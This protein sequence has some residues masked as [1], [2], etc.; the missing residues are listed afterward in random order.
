MGAASGVEA[1]P[2]GV[3]LARLTSALALG[4]TQVR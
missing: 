3:L 4:D 1:M 2:T